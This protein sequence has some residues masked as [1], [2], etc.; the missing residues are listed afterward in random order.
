MTDSPPSIRF[1]AVFLLLVSLLL[2]VNACRHIGPG[3]RWERVEQRIASGTAEERRS[4]LEKV[5]SD[6]DPALR[7]TL[8]NVLAND[9]NPV[10]RAL[11]AE[12]L[13]NLKDPR[14]AD[15][16]RYAL[17]RDTN[18]SVRK[19]ALIAL[20]DIEQEEAG[21]D[22]LRTIEKDPDPLVRITAVDLSV[23]RLERSVALDILLRAL[24]DESPAVSITAYH[25][26]KSLTGRDIAPDARS[27]WRRQV[28]I[29]L[30]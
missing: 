4:A 19:K 6:P 17:Q 3:R 20:A 18:R 27:Q 13:G 21:E 1:P 26:L 9:R 8:E 14:S 16:V 23:V 2:S 11:A 5:R 29:I 7:G 30:F 10:A 28:E 12:A 24:A 15:R 25:H 22:F